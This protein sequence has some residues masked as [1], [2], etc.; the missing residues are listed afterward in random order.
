MWVQED[1]EEL[2]VPSWPVGELCSWALDGGA[3]CA[4]ATVGAAGCDCMCSGAACRRV[5]AALYDGGAVA[6]KTCAYRRVLPCPA[7]LCS[8]LPCLP[9]GPPA[10]RSR[11]RMRPACYVPFTMLRHWLLV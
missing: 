2:G 11:L 1:M 10:I 8:A 5:A 4:R 3:V 6:A 9:S 7:L